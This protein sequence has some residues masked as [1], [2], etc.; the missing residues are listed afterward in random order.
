[1]NVQ[2]LIAALSKFPAE[3]QVNVPS[4]WGYE[5]VFKVEIEKDSGL[6]GLVY[7]DWEA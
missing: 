7:L 4:G 6:H 5:P 3:A 2:E 1:M